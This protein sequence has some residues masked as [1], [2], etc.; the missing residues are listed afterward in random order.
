MRLILYKEAKKLPALATYPEYAKL[1]T[2]YLKARHLAYLCHKLLERFR[3]CR[4]YIF[5]NIHDLAA[6]LAYEMIVMLHVGMVLHEFISVS[7][8]QVDLSD[9]SNLL[10]QLDSPVDGSY[11]YPFAAAAQPSIDIF[12]SGMIEAILQDVQHFPTLVGTFVS[13]FMQ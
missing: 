4:Q 2:R 5:A 12:G 9:Q 6:F 3:V 11:A 10:Q 7:V 13:C 1:V 8:T